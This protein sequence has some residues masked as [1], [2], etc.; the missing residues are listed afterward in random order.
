MTSRLPQELE[1]KDAVDYA[2]RHLRKL[3]VNSQTWEI[4]YEDPTTGEKWIM[5][6]PHSEAQGGG[7][8]RLRRQS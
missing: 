4:E 7:S 2:E 5:D 6:Y 1:G 3:R 8:P